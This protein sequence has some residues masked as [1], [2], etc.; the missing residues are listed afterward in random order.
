MNIYNYVS[1]RSVAIALALSTS[2]VHAVS[3]SPNGNGQ[4]LIYPYYTL[5]EDRDTLLSVS[6]DSDRGKALRVRIRELLNGRSLLEFNV[7]LSA[8]DTWTAG[9]FALASDGVANLS[10]DDTSCTYP[11]L[12]EGSEL[13]TLPDGRHYVQFRNTAYLD[14]AG[15]KTLDR[16]REGMLEILEMGSVVAGSELEKA[17]A[18]TAIGKP[19]NCAY[20]SQAWATGGIWETNSSPDLGNPT[21]NLHGS[22][23]IVDIFAGRLYSYDASALEDFRVD[24]TD[25]PRGTKSS[26]VMH[27]KPTQPH[28]TLADALTNPSTQIASADVFLHNH[29]IHV[30]YPA[31][32]A[33]DAVTATL[34]TESIANDY[35]LDG[36]GGATTRWIVSMPTRP[37]YTDAAI[38]GTSAIAPFTHTYPA[39]GDDKQACM[40]FDRTAYNRT[41]IEKTAAILA[42]GSLCDTTEE[43]VLLQASDPPDIDAANGT[44]T[45]ILRDK[46]LPAP[47]AMR[48]ANDGTVFTGLPIIGFAE[49][50]FDAQDL[51][52]NRANYS[53]RS[54]HRHAA[55]CTNTA[56]KCD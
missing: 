41:G 49:I 10:T 25:T 7:Y 20:V 53:S 6:N 55:H 56:G 23:I 12:Q 15:P 34:M 46:S 11:S 39:S 24:P 50:N 3:L 47:Y 42:K 9:I 51:G 32:H 31:A 4:V 29:T 8:H 28:P 1:L 33:I 54:E 35:I 30:D 18:P 52:G 21:G 48:A 43:Q 13:L 45:W 27:T 36:R 2:A 17:L 14:D 26:V 44:M 19:T 5:T 16:T 38:V 37:F 22:A 40:P